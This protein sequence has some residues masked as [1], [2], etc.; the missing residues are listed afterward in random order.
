MDLIVD[1]ARDEL[2]QNIEDND[3]RES[4]EGTSQIYSTAPNRLSSSIRSLN[5]QEATRG[6]KEQMTT[7]GAQG[8]E[9]E[10]G[11]TANRRDWSTGDVNAR[12]TCEC[13]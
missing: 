12:G 6:F 5:G 13:A 1:G 10:R 11:I 3:K 7:H 4:K 8:G 2:E 9:V